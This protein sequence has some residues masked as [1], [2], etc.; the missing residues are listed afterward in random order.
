MRKKAK[1][2]KKPLPA[3]GC[4]SEAGRRKE[5]VD[6]RDAALHLRLIQHG[7]HIV[8]LYKKFFPEEFA[9]DGVDYSSAHRLIESYD[10]FSQLVDERLFPVH[11][12]S[13]SD[14]LYEEPAA[15]LDTMS[16]C[17][18]SFAPFLWYN[19]SAGD[20]PTFP[21]ERLIVS[22][23]G[24]GDAEMRAPTGHRFSS[25]KLQEVC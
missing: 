3:E 22:A 24:Y 2:S 18:H 21:V 11:W 23:A 20:D 1:K 12:F 14:W 15:A 6:A 4:G 9:R 7:T 16:L 25:E 17:H 13:S 5:K 10:S 8:E 19:R